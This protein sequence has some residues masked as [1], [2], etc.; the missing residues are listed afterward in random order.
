MKPRGSSCY[1]LLEIFLACLR[2]G[3]LLAQNRVSGAEAFVCV[4]AQGNTSC[5][6][7]VGSCGALAPAYLVFA[8]SSLLSETLVLARCHSVCRAVVLDRTLLCSITASLG[9]RSWRAGTEWPPS[10][11]TACSCSM[12]SRETLCSVRPMKRELSF[13]GIPAPSLPINPPRSR[14]LGGLTRDCIGPRISRYL[15]EMTRTRSK[16]RAVARRFTPHR[17]PHACA[18]LQ[19]KTVLMA[20]AS[21]VRP[22]RSLLRR[23]RP[24]SLGG[25]VIYANFANIMNVC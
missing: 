3:L 9:I 6:V 13:D 4:F 14:P 8:G 23:Q 5:V 1:G 19:S 22:F 18:R 7:V 17:F 15:R 24:L 11:T 25:R 20:L 10:G 2:W 12:G 21:H 16:T